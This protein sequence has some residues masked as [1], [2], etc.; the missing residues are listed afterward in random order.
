MI[1]VNV[2]MDFSIMDLLLVNL[3]T[4]LVLLVL[5]LTLLTV[6]PVPTQIEIPLII[7]NV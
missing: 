2:L 7:A 4:T 5:V 3:A 6:L 1:L